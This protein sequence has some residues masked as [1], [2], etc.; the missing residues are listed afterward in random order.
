LMRLRS[1]G[2]HL[3][4]EGNIRVLAVQTLVS[5]VGFGMFYA[6]WQPYILSTGVGVVDLGVIQS[7]I[8]LSSAAGLFVWGIL[9]DRFGRKPVILASNA[10]RVAALVA[11]VLSGN[12]AFLLAFAFFVGFSA[13]FM[14]GNPARSALV[15][16]SVGRGRL[17][18]AFSTLMAISQITTTLTASVG[19]YIAITAGYLPIFYICIAGD[20]LGLVLMG[21]FL[22]ETREGHAV[23]GE[24]AENSVGRMIDLF[25]PDRGIG[26]LYLITV[27]IGVGYG[28]GYSLLYGALT[29]RYGF[30]P[31]QLGL[32]STA[33]NLTWG[34]SSI[35]F[36]RLSDRFGRRPL[37][38]GSVAMAAITALGFIA[39]RSFEMFLLFEVTSALDPALWIPAWMALVSEKAPS[40]GLSTVMGKLD[41]YSRVAS[42]PAPW[43][44][45]LLYVNFGFSAP[46]VVQ[47]ICLMVEGALVF[48]LKEAPVKRV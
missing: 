43:L 7:V 34:I 33:F 29:D 28:T 46:L 26:T 44:G 9:S 21:L 30:T 35:P 15:S 31:F 1:L 17:A 40:R 27:A 32:L 20:I 6:V 41:A 39:S 13:L 5:Q 36:G 14:Q 19:G 47:L 24:R 12:F 8:N 2:G 4:L 45:G 18:T 38:M 42:I 48:S 11:L 10:S 25:R 23:G 22:K 3:A 37:L 16:E